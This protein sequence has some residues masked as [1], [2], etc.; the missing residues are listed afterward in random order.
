M[1]A[2]EL[3]AKGN[4]ALQSEKYDEAIN[5]YTEAIN[6]DPQ[7]HILYSNRSAA[8]AK[9]GKYSDS[10]SDAE[11]TISLKSDWPK[12]YSRKGAALELLERLD[13]AVVTYQEGLKYDSNNEQLK[14]A[15]KVCKDN[16]ESSQFSFGGPGG[17]AG[18]A[19]MNPFS[20]PRFLAN[21]AMNPKTRELLSD[22]EVQNLVKSLQ[23]NP[24]DI[25]KLLNHPKASQLLGAMFGGMNGSGMSF[26][27]EEEEMETSEN[28]PTTQPT[29]NGT[30]AKKEEPKSD[31]SSNLSEEQK[32]AEKEKELGN[33]AYKK[34][35]FE[36]ALKHYE[37]AIELQPN[38]ITYMTNKAAV[39]FEQ[40]ELEK[41]IEVCEK[42]IDVGRENKADYAL[43]AKAYARIGNAYYK[44]KDLKKA[45]KY[46]DHSLSEQRNP[47]IVKK[48]LQVE[49]EIKETEMLAYINPE[50]AEKEK[51]LGNDA[52]KTGNFPLAMR[53][54]NEAIK[55]NPKDPKLFRNRAQ[56]Y[57]KLMEFQLALKDCDEAIKIDPTFVKAYVQKGATLVVLKEPG[58]AMSAYAKAIELDSECQEAIDGY[59]QC[60]IESNS[61]PEEIRKRAMQDPEV[62]E[63]LRDPAM[64]LILEQMQTDR[65]AVQ[66]HLKNPEIRAKIQKLIESGLIQVR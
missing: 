51:N 14:E 32:N 56:C 54:Y 6:I 41:C 23:K 27:G 44:L 4:A 48:K 17:A 52:Y 45:I 30:S 20:D 66:D 61:N 24:N 7:N 22:P 57:S 19:G 43:I 28:K 13:D 55:R 62:Q 11:K 36:A 65:H 53:H 37:K 46:Y 50:E 60:A 34:K 9:V 64:R 35:D 31:S 40:N 25:A 58:K 33:A 8:Y 2:D 59:R 29:S 21:L 5:Y 16:L 18:G 26:E 12:G 42:A 39:Y 47:D 49:R 10:L 3:K 38:N 1:S 15:L 63:I